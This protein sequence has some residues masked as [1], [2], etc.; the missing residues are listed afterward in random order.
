MDTFKD[1]AGRTVFIIY[2]RAWIGT[3]AGYEYLVNFVLK[4]SSSYTK[5]WY[6]YN[7]QDATSGVSANSIPDPGDMYTQIAAGP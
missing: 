4:N 5:S 6:V 2:G 7:W 3:L 1:A